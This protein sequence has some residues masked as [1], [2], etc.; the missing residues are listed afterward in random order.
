MQCLICTGAAKD[1]TSADFD[2]HVVGCPKCGDYEVAGSIW[3]RFRNA[4]VEERA[5]ALRKAK[6]FQGLAKRPTITTACF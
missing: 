6:S 4:S 3:G 5:S 1:L 2:G